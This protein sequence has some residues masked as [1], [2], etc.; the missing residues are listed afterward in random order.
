MPE[1]E[2][3]AMTDAL[4]SHLKKNCQMPPGRNKLSRKNGNSGAG[5][6]RR[7]MRI[8]KTSK[9]WIFVCSS[10][11]HISLCPCLQITVCWVGPDSPWWLWSVCICIS[12]ALQSRG[13]LNTFAFAAGPL[14]H[15][16]HPPSSHSSAQQKLQRPSPL[17]SS[18]TAFLFWTGWQVAHR[19]VCPF[20]STV[21][22]LV[23]V[24]ST[25]QIR[26][27]VATYKG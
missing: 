15:S 20:D 12:F 17:L 21:N 7:K 1:T 13:H 22:W 16:P 27:P 5:Q 4:A 19:F 6:R 25:I 3:K 14:H 11:R 23:T 18:A 26:L 2:S 9:V 10:P 24:I 8:T